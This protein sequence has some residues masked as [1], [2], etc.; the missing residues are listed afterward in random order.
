MA[1]KQFSKKDVAA[2]IL[3]TAPD[4]GLNR[5]DIADILGLTKRGVSEAIK[6]AED[7]GLLAEYRARKADVLN[8]LQLATADAILNKDLSYESAADLTRM[9]NVFYK[10]GRLEEGKA[11]SNMAV[12]F[13]AINTATAERLQPPKAQSEPQTQSQQTD[14]SDQM[15]FDV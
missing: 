1:K 4:S 14:Y 12:L 9:Y 6:R 5:D 2:A 13:N 15:D 10:N 11:T 8:T 3:L 7:S